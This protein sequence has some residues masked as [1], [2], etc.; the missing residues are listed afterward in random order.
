MGW[1]W[2]LGVTAQNCSVGL[3]GLHGDNKVIWTLTGRWPTI[4]NQLVELLIIF[5]EVRYVAKE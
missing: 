4:W 3:G 1:L 5:A 2:D